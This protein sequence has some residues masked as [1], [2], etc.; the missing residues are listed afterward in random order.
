MNGVIRGTTPTFRFTYDNV[1]VSAIVVAYLTIQYGSDIIIEK[2]LKD[3][4]IGEKTLSWKLTQAETLKLGQLSCKVVLV[5]CRFRL[6]DGS[7][8]ASD[9]Y[10]VSVSRILKDGEI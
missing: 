7:A 6:N 3:A 4:V 10:S 1:N 9:I 8:G 2:E 5:Q